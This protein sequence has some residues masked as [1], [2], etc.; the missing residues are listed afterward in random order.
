VITWQE[1]RR[2]RVRMF[3]DGAVTHF[4]IPTQ[5]KKKENIKKSKKYIQKKIKKS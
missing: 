1:I 2:D 4:W 3:I 5:K